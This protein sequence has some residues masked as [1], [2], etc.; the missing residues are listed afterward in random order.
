MWEDLL[1]VSPI[2]AQDDF[3]ALGGHSLMAAKMVSLIEKQF[4]VSLPLTS[5]FTHPTISQLAGAVLDAAAFGNI[6]IDQPCVRLSPKP[7]RQPLFAL[8]PGTT[9]AL[10]YGRLGGYLAGFT[11]H[12]F[13]FIEA[14]SRIGDYADLITEHDP[15]GP[16]LLLGYSGGGNIAFHVARELERRDRPVS[17]IVLIDA[18]RF[19]RC[20]DFPEEEADRLTSAALETDGVADIISSSIL[21][22]K[23][24]RRVRRYY[25]FSPQSSRMPI[26]ADIHLISNPTGE[27]EYR[28]EAGTLIASK[29]AWAEIT[30]GRFHRH[31]G[32]GDH[33]DM[34]RDPHFRNNA[35]LLENILHAAARTP[36]LS[37]IPLR[38]SI[39][40]GDCNERTGKIRPLDPLRQAEPGSPTAA[41]LPALCWRRRVHQELG[42]PA[43]QHRGL[44]HSASRARGPDRGN[45]VPPGRATPAGL[46]GPAPSVSRPAG[47][48]FRSLDGCLSLL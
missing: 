9:D 2:D 16:H 10:S 29:P 41:L 40:I 34:L 25:A 21:R 45:T 46:A 33:G 12:A 28:D 42:R 11:L 47:R 23:I 30:S 22:D 44:R 6:S 27:D 17:A 26:K 39:T 19:L 31:D 37:Q 38:H 5:I 3:F 35:A 7:D 24:R 13:N 18:S 1:G 43:G 14:E 4:G 15:D 48:I 32:N 8:P 20:F 36:S